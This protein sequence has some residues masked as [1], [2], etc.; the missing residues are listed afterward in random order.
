MAPQGGPRGRAAILAVDTRRS[1]RLNGCG[2]NLGRMGRDRQDWRKGELIMR[3][4]IIAAALIAASAYSVSA[5]DVAKGEISFH[6]CLPCHSIGDDAQNKI[7][8]ELNGIDGRHSGSVP[9]FS[10]SDANKN[11][12]IVWDEAQFKDYIKDPRAKIPGT[13]MI[14]AGIKNEQEIS[15]LWAYVSQFNADGSIK[16]K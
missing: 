14:F 8:P 4:L 16:K 5:Q 15:D 12:G 9:D 2:A 10:Y 6:K 13:K 7:G 11:S 3:T 1:G